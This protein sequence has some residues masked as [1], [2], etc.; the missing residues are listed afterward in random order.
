MAIDF[1]RVIVQ[2]GG[3]R[4]DSEGGNFFATRT[5]AGWGI[6][7]TGMT[8]TGQLI[9]DVVDGKF[10]VSPAHHVAF[11]IGGDMVSLTCILLHCQLE[12]DRQEG[13]TRTTFPGTDL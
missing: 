5:P 11:D 12:T 6:Y 3:D 9:G 10:I 2:K 8:H 1:T 13:K 4:I 7:F